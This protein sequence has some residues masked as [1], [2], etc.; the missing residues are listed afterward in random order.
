M[1]YAVEHTTTYQYHEL[2]SLCHNIAALSPRNT[3]T[4]TCKAFNILISPL[5]EILEEHTDFFGNKLY[6]FVIEQEHEKLTVTVKL[7][8][9]KS[10]TTNACKTAPVQ[11]WESVRNLISS[12]RGAYM[13]EKQFTLPTEITTSTPEIKMY[14]EKI[15]TSGKPLFNAVYDLIKNIYTDFIFTPGFTTISTPLSVVMKE[16]KGVCQDFAHLAI[17]CIHSMGLPT[18]YVS[19]YLET[20]APVGKEKLIGVDASH[21]WISVFIPEMGWVDFDPTNNQLATEQ[22]ITIGW[23]RDYFDIIPLKGVIMSSSSHELKVS[24]DVRKLEE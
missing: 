21:A 7:Q 15:F 1:L 6:Y 17:S 8:V 18:R 12:S 5:P 24:V 2:V 14:A 23:G 19:G 9:E 3:A 22:Y 10:D 16:K 11:S 4:Q 20:L 13:E